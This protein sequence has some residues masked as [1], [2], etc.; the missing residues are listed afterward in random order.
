MLRPVSSPALPRWPAAWPHAWLAPGLAAAAW[1]IVLAN[2][3]ELAVQRN[4][5]FLGGPLVLLAGM[6]ARLGEFL[7]GRARERLATLPIA[8][9]RHFAAGSRAHV[10]GFAVAA[11]FGVV[12][13]FVANAGDPWRAT[14]LAGDFAWLCAIAAL[15]EPVVPAVAAWAGRRF[16]EEHPVRQ[17]QR[18]LGGGWTTPEATVHLY[19]PALGLALAV[20]LAMPGQLVLG[21]VADGRAWTPGLALLLGSPLLVSCGLRWAA[22]R[23]YVVGFFAAVAWLCEATRSLAGP[24]EPPPRPA[25]LVRVR[26]PMLRL[27]LTQ[28]L[29]GT[30]LPVLRAYLVL[31][32]A[33]YLGLRDAGPTAPTIALGLGLAALWLMPLQTMARQQRRDAAMLARLPIAGSPR[34]AIGAL[35]ATPPLILALVISGRA[36]AS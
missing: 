32:W 5:V 8:T 6:H 13:I 19:A 29:R 4:L 7:H 24:P 22:P 1:S 21:L 20:T 31:G 25:W 16:P 15:V 35:F 2:V 23:I 3:A 17:A 26:A 10:R 28:W 18:Q 34:A 11:G 30:A 33:A 12:G 27:W 14:L 9:A 36:L